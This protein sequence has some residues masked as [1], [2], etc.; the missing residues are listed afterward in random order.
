MTRGGGA[1]ASAG[2]GH[3]ELVVVARATATAT[4]LQEPHASR[5]E[6]VDGAD[7]P[8]GCLRAPRL[9][10]RRPLELSDRMTHVRFD[11]RVQQ[12]LARLTGIES[13]KCR[14]DFGEKHFD[15]RLQFGAMEARIY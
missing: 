5:L 12:R 1:R 4:S 10:L 3:S 7:K 11:R 6:L 15:A 8:H 14:R 13:G 9:N 2:N